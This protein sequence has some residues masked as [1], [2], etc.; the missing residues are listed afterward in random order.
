MCGIFAQFQYHPL[1]KYED[2]KMIANH[3]APAF[4]LMQCYKFWRAQENIF[5]N[6]LSILIALSVKTRPVSV[7]PVEKDKE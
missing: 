6:K 2:S 4:F 7:S 1:I 3:Q 5:S